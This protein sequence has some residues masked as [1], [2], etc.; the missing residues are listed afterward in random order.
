MPST[1]ERYEVSEIMRG[2]YGPGI[3]GLKQAFDRYWVT[4]L[5]EDIE[6]LFNEARQEGALVP[7]GP[8]RYYSEIHPERLRGFLDIVRHPWFVA[9][10]EAVL[11][12]DYKIVEVGYDMPGPGA[13]DQPWH[14]DFP[15]P[16]ASLRG[17]RLNSLAF[18]ITAV[19][20]TKDLCPF[21]IAP[22][23]QWDRWD[24]NEMFPPRSLYGRYEAR[25]EIKLPQMGDISARTALM[26]HRGRKNLTDRSRP[27]L[28]VGVDAPDATNA[29]RHDVQ[30]TR[31]YY[32]NLSAAEARHFTC[33][34][35]DELEP[36]VQAHDIEELRA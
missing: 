15:S 5:H 8:D 3:I 26:I 29:L 10:C 33:R 20:C 34:V 13:Q 6:Q 28:V 27:V 16:E 19:D 9:V 30:F 14:R 36:I 23:T 1:E 22:G 31:P 11:G 12:P 18:N 32:E 4:A 25:A 7:R 35:V 17:R 21:E 24:G 2:L